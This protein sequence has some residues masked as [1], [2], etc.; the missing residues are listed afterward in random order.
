VQFAGAS[1]WRRKRSRRCKAGSRRKLRLCLAASGGG[2]LRQLL[3]LEPAWSNYDSF[4]VSEKTALAKTLASTHRVRFVRHFAMGQARLGR[5]IFMMA[6]AAI[7]FAQSARIM[8][9]ERPDVVITTGAG[10]VFFSV[11]WAKIFGAKTILIESFARFDRPSLFG[12]I[13]SP[14]ATKKIAQSSALS[15]F[16]PDAEIFDPLRVI[17]RHSKPKEPLLFATVGA[18]LPFERMVAWVAELKQ[19]GLIPEEVIAQV[20]EGSLTRPGIN[21]VESIPFDQLQEILVSANLVVCHG[22]TGSIITALRQACRIVAVP[23]LL[24][25]GEGYD[26]HQLEIC[27]AFR[28]RG[29]I[30]V[31]QSKEELIQQLDLARQDL[32][33]AVDIAPD[34]LVK[35]LIVTLR[36]WS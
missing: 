22:G 31:A 28:D 10:A 24:E 12:R 5:P 7:N 35:W 15:T 36:S 4:F 21:T 2:H 9:F 32:P 20:G 8:L 23:R 18:I 30:R 26:D 13:T 34:E 14:L 3:D 25:N 11:F 17:D 29:L 33:A 6:A 16:W 27:R 19:D 1:L